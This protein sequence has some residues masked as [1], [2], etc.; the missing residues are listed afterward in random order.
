MAKYLKKFQNN[1]QYEAYTASTVFITP[2]VSYCTQEGDIHYTSSSKP[3]TPVIRAITYSASSKLEVDLTAFTPAA[4]AET[5]NGSVGKIEFNALVT[6]IGNGAFSGAT[7]LTSIDMPDTVT[8]IGDYAF[9]NCSGLTSCTLG[10]GVTSIGQFAFT[11]CTS[12]P[13]VTIPDSVT[14]I[15]NGAFFMCSRLTSCTLGSGVTSIGQSA[16]YYCSSLTSI[17]VDAA[18]PP[19]LGANAFSNTNNCPIYV[20]SGSVEDYKTASGWSNY[21]SRIQEKH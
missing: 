12:L 13:S 19:T 8:T 7:A 11:Y 2:N 15:G 20:P 17:T 10:S 9:Q 16:F 6:A 18:T 3:P 14:S 5:F 4:T 21:S 1:T